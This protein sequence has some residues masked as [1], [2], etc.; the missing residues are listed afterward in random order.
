MV[1]LRE[2][3]LAA[4]CRDVLPYLQH[5][6]ENEIYLQIKRALA[7][8]AKPPRRRVVVHV[9]GGVAEVAWQDRGTKVKILDF[10]NCPT[11][12]GEFCQGGHVQP[13]PKAKAAQ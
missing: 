3:T 6:S 7:I 12:G 11:C 9:S 10:D 8:K 5:R 4:A 1:N 2:A 13:C